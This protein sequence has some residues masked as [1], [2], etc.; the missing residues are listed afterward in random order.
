[1][2]R[3]NQ[4]TI[5]RKFV[6]ADYQYFVDH[7]QGD[8]IFTTL[9]APVSL[10]SLINSGAELLSQ[11]VLSISVLALLFSLSWQGTLVFLFMGLLYYIFTGYLS[12]KVSYSSGRMQRE[13]ARES[14]VV[15]IETIDG[16][17][18]L[19]V[20]NVTADWLRKFGNI[21]TT[22]WHHYIRIFTW[23]QALVPVLMLILYLFIGG[24]AL[25]IKLLFPNSFGTLIPIFGTFAFAVFRMVPIMTG[26]TSAIMQIMAALPNCETVYHVLKE[27]LATITD[28][29]QEMNT[30]KDGVRFHNVAFAYKGRERQDDSYCGRFWFRKN[31]HR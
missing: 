20:F 14:N 19:K 3:N 27:R 13:A 4:Q 24:I 15:L 17:K 6:E 29:V 10:Q 22:Q 9:S 16:I 23:Q 1:L 12:N 31:Y 2:V 28:G 11:I 30:F 18:Q 25:I 7:K 26:I 5:Y 8:I 21:I